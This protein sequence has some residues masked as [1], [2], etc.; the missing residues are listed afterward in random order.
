MAYS[1]PSLSRIC[2][3]LAREEGRG[4]ARQWSV[5]WHICCTIRPHRTPL[6]PAKTPAASQLSEIRDQGRDHGAQVQLGAPE[7]FMRKS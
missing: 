4:P 3:R 2:C 5:S 1:L 6:D 7:K